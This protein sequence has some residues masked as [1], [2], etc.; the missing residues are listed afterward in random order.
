MQFRGHVVQFG[1]NLYRLRVVCEELVSTKDL[2]DARRIVVVVIQ[3]IRP[4]KVLLEHLQSRRVT[5]V[6]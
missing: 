2:I 1:D 6:S 3:L 4:V 5:D